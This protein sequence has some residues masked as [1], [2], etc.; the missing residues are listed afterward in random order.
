MTVRL[1]FSDLV[2]LQSRLVLMPRIEEEGVGAILASYT[3]VATPRATSEKE[4]F[5]EEKKVDE[6][7]TIPHGDIETVESIDSGVLTGTQVDTDEGP[8]TIDGNVDIQSA[9][10]TS[11]PVGAEPLETEGISQPAEALPIETVDIIPEELVGKALIGID[12]VETEDW[13]VSDFSEILASIRK[14]KSPIVLKFDSNPTEHTSEDENEAE[15]S[16]A[17]VATENSRETEDKSKGASNS[18]SSWGKLAATAASSA[19]VYASAT[20]TVVASKAAEAR[21]ARQL[22]PTIVALPPPDQKCCAYLQMKDGSFTMLTSGAPNKLPKVTTTSIIVVRQAPSQ[23]C[24]TKGYVFQWFRS[25]NAPKGSDMSSSSSRA[26]ATSSQGGG[27]VDD[28]E[29]WTMLEGATYTAYQPSATDIGH[30]LKCVV[31]IDVNEDEGNAAEDQSVTQETVVC[32]TPSP[33]SADMPMFN[34]ARQALSRGAKFSSLVGRGSAEGRTFGILI[35]IAI[36]SADKSISSATTIE[37]I[38]GNTSEPIHLGAIAKASAIADPSNPKQFDL[39]FPSGLPEGSSMVSALSTDGRFQLTT[40]NRMTRETLLLALGIANY[41]GQPC[42]LTETTVLYPGQV[43][44]PGLTVKE[45]SIE[46]PVKQHTRRA[47]VE[48]FTPQ[49]TYPIRS[50]EDD[51][52]DARFCALELEL[53]QMRSKLSRKDKVVSDLQ[54]QLTQTAAKVEKSER[55]ISSYQK[56]LQRTLE[57]SKETRTK[58]RAAEKRI[59]TH[60]AIMIRVK[61]D[62]SRQVL[63]LESKILAQSEKVSELEKTAR[64]LQ[65]E[66]AVLSAAVEARDSKLDKMKDLQKAMETLSTKVAKGDTLRSELSDMGKRYEVLCNDLEKVA[67][68]ETEC[69]EQLESA[70]STMNKLYQNLESEATRRNS[71]QQELETVQ[72]ASQKLKAERNSYK[73]KADSLSKE[74]ARLCRGGRT[75]RDVEKALVDE[76]SRKTEVQLLRSQKQQALADLHQYRTSYE[77]QLV[78]QLNMGVNGAAIQALEQKAALERVVADLTEYVTAKEMQLDTM[79]QVNEALADEMKLLA[80]ANMDKNDI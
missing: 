60:E 16:A 32:E 45:S 47:D 73:Q 24:P 33:I 13:L 20:A 17:D 15:E 41:S 54:R 28:D 53:Q 58:L 36:S 3:P 74:V 40:P 38:S 7:D 78:A 11:D 39:V 55:T 6:D 14:A 49:E 46:T 51:Q 12:G 48:F 76:E 37:Q 23:P 8:S 2:D 18:W 50:G 62:H 30:R 77:H 44:H 42:D 27:S 52:S 5:Q 29:Q 66:K 72:R 59:E 80:K 43:Q 56:D 64:T 61:G 31:T 75:L 34:A 10:A 65:N 25:C 21:A 57:D 9:P 26:S 67:A 69:K 22:K 68:S 70:Q 4:S 63:M 71:S 35:E 79:R 1:S 19:K